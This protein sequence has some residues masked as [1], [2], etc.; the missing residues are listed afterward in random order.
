MMRRCRGL[1]DKRKKR[2][3]AKANRRY[4]RRH[5]LS[6]KLKFGHRF[7]RISKTERICQ[8]CGNYK[9]TIREQR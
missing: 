2:L 4:Y 5:Q 3:Q 6:H 8:V 9:L 7:K 1:R